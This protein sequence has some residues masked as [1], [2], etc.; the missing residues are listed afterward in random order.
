MRCHLSAGLFA[1][2][3]ALAGCTAPPELGAPSGGPDLQQVA[4]RF[5]ADPQSNRKTTGDQV[6]L[7]FIDTAGAEVDLASFRGRS[8]VVL[9]VVKGLPKF[10]GGKFCPGCLAQVNSLTANYDEFKKRDATI[11]MVFPG[12]KDALPQFLADAKVDG[13]AGNP[14]VPFALLLDTDLE[15]VKALGI[16]GD[17]AK[18][19]TY[20]LDKKGNA[21]F[22]F[23]GETTTDRPSVQ[24]LLT[25]LDKLN[26]RK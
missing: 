25:Q 24:A 16:T 21:V 15:A 6:P 5:L 14:K 10:P 4:S 23:V 17:L 3:C 8:N 7:K 1:V 22:A 20:I 2:L 12:P 19:S 26:A 13:T 9:V 18:P 11:L